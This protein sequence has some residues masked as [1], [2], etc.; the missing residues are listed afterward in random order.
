VSPRILRR[1]GPC[2]HAVRPSRGTPHRVICCG[3]AIG[4]DHVV[5][6]KTL[7]QTR[8]ANLKALN[9]TFRFIDKTMSSTRWQRRHGSNR[10]IN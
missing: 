1:S 8:A 7:E 6:G 9:A 5:I 2:G 10:R 3:I 4:I